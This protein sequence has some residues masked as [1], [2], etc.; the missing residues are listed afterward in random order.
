MQKG[1]GTYMF[2]LVT[3]RVALFLSLVGVVR[4]KWTM[5]LNLSPTGKVAPFPGTQKVGGDRCW[6]SSK[7]RGPVCF[8]FF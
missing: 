6:I 8:F 3:G 2:G 4:M 7:A 5:S 1:K